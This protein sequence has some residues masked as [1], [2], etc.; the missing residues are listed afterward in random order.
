MRVVSL[1]CA[2]AVAACAGSPPAAKAG[3]KAGAEK[4]AGAAAR[5]PQSQFEPR[6]APGRGQELLARMAGDWDVEKTLHPR[7]GDPVVSHGTC[8]Q[9]MVHGG[10]FLQCEFTFPGADGAT[11]G[12]GT[13]GFDAQTARFTSFWVDS[14]STRVSVR[15]S[16]GSFDGGDAI[17]LVGRSLGDEA[18]P[19]RSRTESRLQDGDRVLTHR[20]WGIAADGSERL[21]MELRLT[22]RG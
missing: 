10:R 21:V 20:Q 5:D 7:N 11:T 12:S 2:L 19:R 22:R 17:Q 14:R 9:A 3:E 4:P 13:I 16:E 6:S 8:H 18:S 15:Q 1:L